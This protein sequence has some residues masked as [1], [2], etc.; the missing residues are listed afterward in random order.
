M[1]DLVGQKFG[2][3]IVKE[4][5]FT[6]NKN[7][8]WLC[9]CECGNEKNIKQSNLINGNSK[10]CGCSKYSDLTG[11]KFGRLIV[12]KLHNRE[13]NAKWLCRCECGNE[14]IVSQGNL[15]TNHIQSCGCL[16]K[17]VH[18]IGN[19]KHNLY[20]TRIYKIWKGMKDR[21]Y[22]ITNQAYERYGGRG[23]TICDEWKNN[24]ENFY[25]WSMENGYEENLTIDR[26]DNNKGYSPDNCRWATRLEQ[27]NN[28][29]KNIYYE[30]N[31]EK[32]TLSQLSR[33][34]KIAIPTLYKRLKKFDNVKK[35][36][37]T[38]IKNKTKKEKEE[39]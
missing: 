27:Q 13:K 37:E 17:E 20:Y 34:Y 11:K 1:K 29:R 14:K 9:K 21:C 22:L 10:S 36:I 28:T 2:K 32:L 25:N 24:V 5:A 8:F 31:G 35:A 26:I 16:F 23:I 38:P 6:K 18:K 33:K 19:P 7:N 3:W 12:I 15:I 30:Y 4:F 39:K